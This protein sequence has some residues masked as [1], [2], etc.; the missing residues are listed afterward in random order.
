MPEA[1]IHKDSNPQS[2][3]HHV[4]S[5]AETWYGR[6]VDAISHAISMQQSPNREF[7]LRISPPLSQHA[8]ECFRRGC[9]RT[10]TGSRSNYYVGVATTFI[11]DTDHLLIAS[12]S[13]G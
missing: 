1:S 13:A 2:R 6:R 7:R 3:K 8:S 4:S 9:S 10:T 5:S 11:A 12:S